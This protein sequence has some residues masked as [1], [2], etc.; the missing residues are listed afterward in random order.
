METN[1]LTH[2]SGAWTF[3]KR[4]PEPEDKGYTN[5]W[6]AAVCFGVIVFT[7]QKSG[8]LSHFWRAEYSAPDSNLTTDTQKTMQTMQ[9][10]Y[11]W[12]GFSI[13]DKH[14]SSTY[15]GISHLDHA[16]VQLRSIAATS[17]S[18]ICMGQS[19]DTQNQS[20]HA[21]HLF[22]IDLSDSQLQTFSTS[23]FELQGSPFFESKIRNHRFVIPM[24]QIISW[25][26]VLH[27]QH[28]EISHFKIQSDWAAQQYAQRC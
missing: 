22:T 13:S 3:Q 25:I 19:K 27:G 24:Y 28:L 14:L 16:F 17:R 23:S 15:T 1:R 26:A 7:V 9:Y 2:C 4:D 8:K 6:C 11:L 20:R 12:Q 5:K 10:S 21:A 18:Q